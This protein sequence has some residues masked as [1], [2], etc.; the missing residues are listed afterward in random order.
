MKGNEYR[1]NYPNTEISFSPRALI[2]D[3]SQKIEARLES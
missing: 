2:K 3:Y 1:N